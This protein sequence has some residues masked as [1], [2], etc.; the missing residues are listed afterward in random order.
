MAMAR[1]ADRFRR[2]QSAHSGDEPSRSVPASLLSVEIDDEDDFPQDI[3]PDPVVEKDTRSALMRKLSDEPASLP[4]KRFGLRLR[5]AAGDDTILSATPSAGRKA[6]AGRAGWLARLKGREE[7][8]A[9]PSQ[10]EIAD[11][12]FDDIR[13][14]LAEQDAAPRP[15][16]D[17]H[18]AEK[19]LSL[20]L[21]KAG[22]LSDE[23]AKCSAALE[24][25]RS[26]I[27][28]EELKIARLRGVHEGLG[29]Q[30]D[31]QRADLDAIQETLDG[32]RRMVDRL[33]EPK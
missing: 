30:T 6:M 17:L 16:V 22:W 4:R 14:Q 32:L 27:R 3:A 9:M 13:Q 26:L 31:A 1:F 10:D 11:D 19:R 8:P 28:E 18:H 12:V 29:G 5:A 21:S 7:T 33:D 2:T 25:A 24:D 23:I 20:A 15:A